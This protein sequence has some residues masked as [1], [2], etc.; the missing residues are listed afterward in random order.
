MQIPLTQ[1]HR[2]AVSQA[3]QLNPP[4][5]LTAAPHTPHQQLNR[6]WR[7][8]RPL[9][10]DRTTAQTGFPPPVNIPITSP[11]TTEFAQ[12]ILTQS[13]H[14]PVINPPHTPTQPSFPPPPQSSD[15]AVMPIE[16]VSASS[17]AQIPAVLR[18]RQPSSPKTGLIMAAVIGFVALGA[19]GAFFFN[20]N[21]DS[22]LSLNE[23]AFDSYDAFA[24][25]T[26]PVAIA[27]PDTTS[28][29]LGLNDEQPVATSSA[30]LTATD[31]ATLV[32]LGEDGEKIAVKKD[33]YTIILYGDLMIDA[34]DTHLEKI[35][36]EFARKYDASFTVY[37]YG[38]AEE[39]AEEGL[40][41]FSE[42]LQFMGRDYPPLAD[43]E[44]DIIIIGSYA[45]HPTDPYN[46]DAHWLGIAGLVEAAKKT[47]AAVYLMTDIA[48]LGADFG[49][50]T[51]A[52]T[53][54]QR[55]EHAR[56][57]IQQLENVM[58]LS[59]GLDV[60]LID[61]YDRTQKEDGFGSSTF[62]DSS[63]GITPNGIGKDV[64]VNE[65]VKRIVIE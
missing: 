50:R 25:R 59:D 44:P 4:S 41:R 39:T 13:E 16:A 47:N 20:A 26:Q 43:L 5:P 9:G 35:E 28:A 37:N 64:A 54:Q 11:E 6:Q 61:L 34:L 52:W 48:P 30:S 15:P 18:D 31:S 1:V 45:Y 33:E 40:E 36:A 27:E 56:I 63:T 7:F 60:R 2:S 29:V 32:E 21:S 8:G 12:N 19:G 22:T 53:T 42:P 17:P 49:K 24:A 51:F 58:A 14:T 23:D 65:M 38:V 10:A 3:Q 57:I 46:R 62:T 55:I